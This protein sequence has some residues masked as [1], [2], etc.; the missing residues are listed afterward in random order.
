MP[1]VEELQ[2]ELVPSVPSSIQTPNQSQGT[3]VTGIVGSPIKLINP[4]SLPLF[5]EADH[6]PKD[7]TIYEQWLLQ[8]RGAL[9]SHT[10]EAVQS[11]I[12]RSIGVR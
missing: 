6:T 11:G 3:L 8:A 7:E 5:L 10:E 1:K 4:P 2:K 12:I 9:N